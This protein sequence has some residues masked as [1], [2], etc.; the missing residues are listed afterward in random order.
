MTAT[1]QLIMLAAR[2]MV[3]ERGYHALSF[4]D[5]AQQVGIK[6]SSVHHHFYSKDALAIALVQDYV[7]V[8]A[9]VLATIIQEEHD[10]AAR[11]QL[12]TDI[13]RRALVDGNRMCLCGILNAQ[14]ISEQAREQVARF[15]DLNINWLSRVLVDVNGASATAE[16][17]L[18]IFAA[19][20]GAQLAARG[21]ADIN[22][23]D[24]AIEGYRT[25]GLLP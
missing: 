8:A 10:V 18:A 17:A 19:Q 4:R 14:T 3:Q 15:T 9:K 6:S 24:S 1:R 5:L 21:A 20:E 7:N 2:S 12:Y 23:F 25:T 13:F 16:W 11:I 22:V